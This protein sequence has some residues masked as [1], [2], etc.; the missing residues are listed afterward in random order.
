MFSFFCP[1]F[2]VNMLYWF[3]VIEI[4]TEGICTLPFWASALENTGYLA[5]MSDPEKAH[6]AGVLTSLTACVFK[7]I[8]LECRTMEERQLAFSE[9]GQQWEEL[10]L[11]F[12]VCLCF[13]HLGQ[14][15]VPLFSPAAAYFPSTR[16]LEPREV[17]GT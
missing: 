7:V 11:S 8:N 17:L 13:D 15:N 2:I 6:R 14:S 5:G 9:G 12:K 4:Y 1:Y 10:C 3:I 16:L